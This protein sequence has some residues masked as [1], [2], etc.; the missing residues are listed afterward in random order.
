MR[1]R[2]VCHSAA[3]LPKVIVTMAMTTISWAH[4]MLSQTG[5]MLS[6]IGR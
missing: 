3:R 2:F 1:L 6:P 5:G 4:G